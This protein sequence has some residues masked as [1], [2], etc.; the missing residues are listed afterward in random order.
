MVST[1]TS[2]NG[3]RSKEQPLPFLPEISEHFYR[4]DKPGE[5]CWLG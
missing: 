4:K 3:N 5:T 1:I 2:V